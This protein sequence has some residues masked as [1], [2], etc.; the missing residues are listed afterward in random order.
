[1]IIHS[2]IMEEIVE[3]T[4]NVIKQKP[5]WID[6]VKNFN[7]ETTG[8]IYSDSDIINEIITAI[9]E[10]NPLHSATSLGLCLQSCKAILNK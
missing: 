9:D 7:D 10:V 4:L 2:N 1:M 5:E 3:R 6:S 8:F